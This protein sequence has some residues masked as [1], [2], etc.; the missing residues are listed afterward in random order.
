MKKIIVSGLFIYP[1]KSFAGVSIQSSE[2][3][4]MGLKYDRR[5]MVVTTEGKFVTQRT[6]PKMALIRTALDKNGELTLSTQGKSDHQ[7]VPVNNDSE[8]MNVIIWRDKL[9]VQKAANDTDLWISEVLEMDCHLVYISN[10]VERQ[11]NLEYAK[12]GDRTGFADA[13]PMLM[14]SEE[15]LEDLNARLDNPVEMR[16]FRPNIVIKGCDAFA[17]DKMET[18]KIAEIAMNG[19]KLCDRCPM[20]T[21]D[22]DKG[23]RDGQEP[24]ITLAKYRKWDGKVY[25]GMNVIHRELG[26]IR[27]GDEL[28]ET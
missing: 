23:E 28:V 4:D 14:V 5:W 24:I 26:I 10:N 3:D 13:Y 11:C 18:F 12:Q 9:Q 8:K 19:V 6:L 22:P 1:V 7:V 16:R 2:L 27:V 17:E 15:S 21:V 20:P 25:F